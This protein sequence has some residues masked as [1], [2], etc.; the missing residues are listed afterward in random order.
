MI[1]GQNSQLSCKFSGNH[2]CQILSHGSDHTAFD[3]LLHSELLFI[4]SQISLAQTS[5]QISF[6]AKVRPY[7][8]AIDSE[9]GLKPVAWWNQKRP[10]PPHFPKLKYSITKL[11]KSTVFFERVV[12]CFRYKIV[13]QCFVHFQLSG[14]PNFFGMRSMQSKVL[15][16]I[17]LDGPGKI[18]ITTISVSVAISQR[19]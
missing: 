4:S 14:V 16:R 5:L 3:K 11:I 6:F 19:Q 7:K 1:N 18:L 15:L 12:L 8:H 17:T 9:I 13:F 10:T 2:S